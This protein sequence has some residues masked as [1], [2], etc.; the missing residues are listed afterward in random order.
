MSNLSLEWKFGYF[1]SIIQFLVLTFT[2]HYATFKINLIHLENTLSLT[3]Q[4]DCS[5]TLFYRKIIERLPVRAA[6]SAFGTKMAA[7]NAKRSISTITRKN[8]GLC[9][10]YWW[11]DAKNGFYFLSNWN[12]ALTF[13]PRRPKSS[14]FHI[15]FILFCQD[16]VFCLFVLF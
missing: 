8:R 6:I 13:L 2:D 11:D 3:D 4:I 7:C 1:V 12:F 5:K 15:T 9:L 16:F 10:V 14:V